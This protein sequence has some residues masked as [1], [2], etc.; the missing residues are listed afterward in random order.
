MRRDDHGALFALVGVAL[1]VFAPLVVYAVRLAV[2][3]GLG[4]RP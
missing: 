4:V 3:A 2:A 1:V